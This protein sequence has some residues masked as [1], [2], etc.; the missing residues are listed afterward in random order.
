[1]RCHILVGHFAH[2]ASRHNSDVSIQPT[3]ATRVDAF[4]KGLAISGSL[5][6]LKFVSRATCPSKE[7][8]A[9]SAGIHALVRHRCLPSADKT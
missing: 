3:L 8:G 4:W 2:L 5:D 6:A 7:D 1:M 9:G